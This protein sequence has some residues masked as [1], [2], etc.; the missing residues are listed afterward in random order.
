VSA[1]GT[2]RVLPSAAGSG[3][4][5]L[6][7]TLGVMGLDQ[8]TKGWIEVHFALFERRAV[9]PVLD[10]TRMHNPGAAF[11]FLASETGWQRWVFTALAITVGAGIIVWLR[12]LNARAQPLLCAGLA[13]VLAGALGNVV[14]RLRLGYVVDFIH[15]H[16]NDAYFPA[17]NVSDSSI[18]IGAALLLLDAG[19]ES[20]RERRNSRA[21]GGSNSLS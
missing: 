14:D 6:P 8:L 19:R 10:V 13:L 7:L 2:Q 20:I 5:W 16:W 18:T 11:S 9:L 15:A 1:A 4:R 3:W 21:P 12:R 17:F